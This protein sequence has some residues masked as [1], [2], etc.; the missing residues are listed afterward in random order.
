VLQ[1]LIT[2]F[3]V[4]HPP[5]FTDMCSGSEAGSY[6]RLIDVVYHPTLG[7]RVIKKKKT[8]NPKGSLSLSFS[9]VALSGSE[10]RGNNLK[11]LMTLTWEPRPESVL[12]CLICAIF[13]RQ[14]KPYSRTSLIRNCPPPLGS[15]Y[16]PRQ[17]PT[18]YGPR[19]SPTAGS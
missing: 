7:L 15:P 19:Q 2:L 3:V 10:R 5:Y 13:A 9:G 11:G 16:G 18:P 4:L 12:D 8:R 1:P 14:R 17:R 6:L